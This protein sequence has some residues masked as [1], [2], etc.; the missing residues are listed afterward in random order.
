MHKPAIGLL[1]VATALLA[2]LLVGCTDEPTV[3]LIRTATPTSVPPP[4][5]TAVP[6]QASEPMPESTTAPTGPSRPTPTPESTAMPTTTRRPAAT[7]TS[8]AAPTLDSPG[9]RRCRAEM[10]MREGDYCTVSIPRV[11]VG[12]E[13]FEIRDGRGCYGNLCGGTGLTLNDFIAHKNSDESWTIERVP[14]ITPSD[15]VSA[16]ATATPAP[17]ATQVPATAPTA[18]PRPRSSPT[19]TLTQSR[20][21]GECRSGLVVRPGESCTYPESSQVLSVDVDGKGRWS[22]L[23][24][25][26]F[27]G[28]INLGVTVNGREEKFVARPQGD[29]SWIIE[30][31]GDSEVQT[32]GA[33]NT[34][35]P[36]PETP[37][38]ITWDDLFTLELTQCSGEKFTRDSGSARVIVGGTVTAKRAIDAR[39]VLIDLEA[40]ANGE[41]LG[42]RDFIH[43][44]SWSSGESEDFEIHGLIRTSLNTLSCEVRWN[45][46][47]RGLR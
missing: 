15:T 27:S 37:S 22:A 18:T 47:I 17:A 9:D 13:R 42:F 19:A 4:T 39:W 3:Q 10:V 25:L 30:E 41:A 46:E 34:P 24:F 32:S 6:T 38:S 29:G 26:S 43:K 1:A 11:N 35:P 2:I 23:P 40:S 20:E 8:T 14:G 21:N 44:S 36:T 12:T 31:A 33:K 5:S 45:L 28:E 16:T 7:P